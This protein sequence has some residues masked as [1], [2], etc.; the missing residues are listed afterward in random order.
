MN[1][2]ALEAN[3]VYTSDL[4]AVPSHEHVRGYVLAHQAARRHH[5]EVAELNELVGSGVPTKNNAI[6]YSY[7]SREAHLVREDTAVAEEAVVAHMA[8]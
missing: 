1:A 5:H 8:I 4:G 3:A 2:R 6:T 7:V